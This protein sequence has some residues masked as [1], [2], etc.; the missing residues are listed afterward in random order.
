MVDLLSCE[1]SPAQTIQERRLRHE[2]ILRIEPFS[3]ARPHVG[4]QSTRCDFLSDDVSDDLIHRL[5]V[6]RC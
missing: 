6:G 4:A 3:F 2:A 1:R 5:K